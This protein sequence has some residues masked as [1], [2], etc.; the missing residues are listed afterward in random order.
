MNLSAR[1]EAAG[2]RLPEAPKPVASFTPCRVDGDLAFVSGQI[3]DG[4][5][6]RVGADIDAAGAIEAARQCAINVLA[7][8][9]AGLGSLDRV[10]ALLK[11]TVFVNS[12]PEFEEPHVVANGASDLLIELLGE[13]GRHARS[14]VCVASLP[15]GAPVEV[16]AIVRVRPEGEAV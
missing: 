15:L 10:A 12:V 3:A 16:E 5:R 8:L 14:A 13:Q 1:L 7:Q 2:I 11:L 6:G 4:V 9:Q